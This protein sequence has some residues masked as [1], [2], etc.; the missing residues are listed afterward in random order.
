MTSRGLTAWSA[1]QPRPQRS[2]TPGRKF[3]STTSHVG[4]EP[5]DD[6][7][8]L[9][10][11]EVERHELLV[12]VVDGEPVRAAVLGRAEAPEVVAPAGHLGLDHL[13]AELG[14]QRAAERAGDD[15]G[16]LEHADSVERTGGALSWCAESTC[17]AA[18]SA[19][20]LPGAGYRAGGSPQALPRRAALPWP[21]RSVSRRTSM[22][23]AEPGALKSLVD[24]ERGI[25]SR[26]IFVSE[27]IYRQELERVFARAWL[28]VGHE[29]QIPKPGDFLTSSHGRGVGHPVPRPG[30]A[31]P[32]VPQFV[33]APRHEGLP[34]RRGQHGRVPVSVPRLELRHRRRAR[35][36]AVREGRLRRAARPEPSGASSRSPGWKTTRA[37]SGRRGTP[38]RRPSS[39][40]SAATSSTSTCCSTPGTAAR[41]GP[42]RSAASTSGSSPATGSSRPRTS[43][44]TATTA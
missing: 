24:V 27:E 16:E 14:H 2:R 30:R 13:G 43:R 31:D 15:L 28:F 18:G 35:G 6:V 25:I 33:P 4:H 38:R 1:S 12:P 7:L 26:E 10:Q 39:T 17:S 8:A 11:V 32:R 23:S 34:V 36:R 37:R 40:T 5:A 9:R 19:H 41:A 44:A 21:C 42:R 22:A 29:S 20:R 3:S